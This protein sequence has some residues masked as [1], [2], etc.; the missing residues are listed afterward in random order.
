[1][2]GRRGGFW[3]DVLV[4]LTLNFMI[5]SILNLICLVALGFVYMVREGPMLFSKMISAYGI[6]ILMSIPMTMIYRW[7]KRR[8]TIILKEEDVIV[9]DNNGES[10]DRYTV[11]F[12][13]G[14]FALGLSDD[15]DKPNGFSQ[16]FEWNGY[17][18]FMGNKIKFSDLPDN[19]RNHIQIRK[20]NQLLEID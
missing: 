4:L 15:C 20:I 14:G 10:A 18:V 5:L 2:I 1:M 7:S 19:V 17:N 6:V 8:K 16:Y 12:K 11:V 13:R 3:W 9:Y